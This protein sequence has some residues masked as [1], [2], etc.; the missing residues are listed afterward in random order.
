MVEKRICVLNDVYDLTELFFE[1]PK[2]FVL[3]SL[4]PVLNKKTQIILTGVVFLSLLP[5]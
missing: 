4:A 2:T 1:S 3:K 5:S